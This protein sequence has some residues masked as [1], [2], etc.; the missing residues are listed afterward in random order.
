MF[1]MARECTLT[2]RNL[3]CSMITMISENACTIGFIKVMDPQCNLEE[4]RLPGFSF[5]K[6]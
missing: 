4:A 1:E 2:K 3:A 5:P 6:Q